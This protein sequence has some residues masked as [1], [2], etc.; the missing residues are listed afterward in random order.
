MFAG[1]KFFLVYGKCV[2]IQYENEDNFVFSYDEIRP[3]Q[4]K[5]MMSAVSK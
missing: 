4:Q 5:K 3:L 2:H 1:L